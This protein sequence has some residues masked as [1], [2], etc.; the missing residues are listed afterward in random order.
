[1]AIICGVDLSA[2]SSYAIASAAALAERLGEPLWL[3]HAVDPV[4]RALHAPTVKVVEGAIS[5]KLEAEAHPLRARI[6]A[7]VH[8]EL[9]TGSPHEALP[10]FAERKGG[11]ML[12]VASKG[13]GSSP[14][15]R[16]GGTSERVAASS[17]IP[18]IVCR[19]AAPFQAWARGERP[20]RV[21]LGVD[22]SVSCDVAIQWLKDLRK[23]GPCD[24]TVSSVYYAQEAWRRYGLAGK[25]SWVEPDPEVERLVTRDMEARVGKLPGEGAVTF[26][27]KLGLGRLADHLLEVAEAEKVDLIVVGTHRRT[28]V[29]R[30]SSVSSGVLHM[31][32]VAVACVPTAEGVTS[33]T[34]GLPRIQRVLIATD[35]SQFSNL[36]VPYGYALLNATGGEIHLL[37]VVPT[38]EKQ[39]DE[40]LS[41]RLRTLVPEAATHAGVRTHTEIVRGDD[42]ARLIS[43]TAE[44][45]G[46]D[47]ICVTTHGRTGL[48]KALLGSVTEELLTRSH[49]PVLTLRPPRA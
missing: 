13:H 17:K 19:E 22:E 41:A 44:R 2:N 49:R 48:T 35:L 31:A 5:E 27:P 26:R 6:R 40:E 32:G 39:T 18:V 38:S 14:L 28:G 33:R 30:L 16:L 47:I 45:L 7:G 3:V 11:R 9:L 36:A 12:V 21:L 24:V 46:V 37:H 20:L 4:V 42:T 29:A 43:E 15:L 10:A 8:I 1:M 25:G 23:A 34:A